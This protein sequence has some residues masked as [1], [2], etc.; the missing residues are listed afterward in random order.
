MEKLLKDALAVETTLKKQIKG[1]EATILSYQ[2]DGKAML[3]ELR[4]E[5]D[6]LKRAISIYA[7]ECAPATAELEND[8]EAVDW[9]INLANH[10]EEES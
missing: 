1:L 10:Y 6:E 9:F 8:A 2:T 7:R 5:N 4:A 3:D